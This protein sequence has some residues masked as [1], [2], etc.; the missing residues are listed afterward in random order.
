MRRRL[1]DRIIKQWVVRGAAVVV[2]LPTGKPSLGGI[3]VAA[4]EQQAGSLSDPN[5]VANYNELFCL[6]G[7]TGKERSQAYIWVFVDRFR[8]LR[9]GFLSIIID[10]CQR[11]T[12]VYLRKYL[13]LLAMAVIYRTAG[14]N[15]C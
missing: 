11:T 3:H 12:D 14:R 8:F 10:S 7:K 13:T 5:A 2:Y 1:R 4:N 6:T 9:H 15:L